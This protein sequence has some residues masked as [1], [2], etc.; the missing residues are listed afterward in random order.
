MIPKAT[1]IYLEIEKSKIQREKAKLV[2]E[3]SVF[4][5]IIFMLIAVLG[6]VFSS[7]DSSMLNTLILLGIIILIIGTVPYMVLVHKE[8]KKIEGY[9]K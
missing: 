7:I 3:K 9:L 6:F 8:E 2:L 5:Y 1:R 4:L